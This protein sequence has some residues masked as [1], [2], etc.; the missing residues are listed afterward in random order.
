[1]RKALS[2][3]KLKSYK[4]NIR[5]TLSEPTRNGLPSNIPVIEPLVI[6]KGK[7]KK[8]EIEVYGENHSDIDNRFY[9]SI[10]LKNK[11]VMVEHATVLCEISEKDK[12]MMLNHVKGS[13]WIWYKYK[14][15]KNPIICIDN[16][17][18]LGLLSAIEEKYLMQTTDDFES[19]FS[20]TMR[21]LKVLKETHIKKLFTDNNFQNI[22]NDY[23]RVMKR[24]FAILL[25][26]GSIDDDVL[27]IIKN[28][29]IKNI[30]KVASF[31]VDL[32]IVNLIHEEKS[33]K[34]I[35]IFVGAG[36]AYRL[37][38][39]FPNI[40]D[41]IK[42]NDNDPEVIEVLDKLIYEN[43]EVEIELMRLL[44]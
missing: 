23:A 38:K 35:A 6:T 41:H 3:N 37:H 42:I 18:E 32:N 8:I 19:V 15:K 33:K 40:F 16:R 9:E 12:I 39:Y 28:M 34:S 21:V 17:I 4:S 13:D 1:M 22:Y 27:L 25:K 30:Q 29:L 7:Y 14:V 43:E 20:A 24:Q 31:I 11:A 36:H 26:A 44:S 5:K 2:E 10:D